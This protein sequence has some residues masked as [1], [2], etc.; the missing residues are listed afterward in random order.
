MEIEVKRILSNSKTGIEDYQLV[1]PQPLRISHFLT[2]GIL[3]A[4]DVTCLAIASI[5]SI[6]LQVLLLDKSVVSFLQI[7]TF[8]ILC[9][10]AY[11]LFGLYPGFSISP[12]EEMKKLTLSSSLIFLVISLQSFWF[13]DSEKYS[14]L[15]LTLIWLISLGLLPLGRSLTRSISSRLGFIG[16]PTVVIGYG[17]IGKAVVRHLKDNEMVGLHPVAMID[18]HKSRDKRYDDQVPVFQL[19]DPDKLQNFSH[20]SGI[21]TGIMVLSECPSEFLNA[22]SKIEQGGFRRMIFIPNEQEIGSL[23]VKPFDLGSYSGLEVTWSLFNKIWGLIKRIMDIVLV[24]SGGL[25][26]LPFLIMLAIIVKLDSKGSVFYGHIRFGKG[27]REFKAWKFRTM[28]PNADQ[29]LAEYLE[30]DPEL[31]KEWETSYKLRSDPRIT[32]VG[33]ILRKLS[34]DELPQLW[35]VLVG[36]MSLVGPRPIISDEIK[37]YGDVFEMYALVRP[38]I[39]GLWQVS[40]RNDSSYEYRVRLDKYYISNWSIWLDFY[41]LALTVKAVFFGKGAY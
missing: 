26:I 30:K 38:G 6:G 36:E 2:I 37:C 31:R 25:F 14:Y 32:R 41:I 35:N 34:L 11:G 24:I 40:G 7:A 9:I 21:K 39:T 12:V 5:L 1:R 20:L 15:F 33:K 3:I 18:L 4:S 17:Q 22:A 28:V 29:L 8:I 27:K 13:S 16:E 10:C 19:N 23:G